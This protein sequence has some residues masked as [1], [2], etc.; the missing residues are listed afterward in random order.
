MKQDALDLRKLLHGGYKTQHST[1]GPC[2]TFWDG[3]KDT[4]RIATL[5]FGP[6]VEIA[7]Q[8]GKTR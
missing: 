8:L 5:I 4:E 6:K 2:F 1:R 7:N 3:T